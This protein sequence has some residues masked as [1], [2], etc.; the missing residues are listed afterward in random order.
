MSF[1]STSQYEEQVEA[2][3][4]PPTT[5]N[6]AAQIA[7]DP[8]KDYATRASEINAL[9][10]EYPEVTYVLTSADLEEYQFAKY[11]DFFL[12]A[13]SHV[14]QLETFE[15]S[16]PGFS[17]TYRV[18]RNA[19]KGLTAT[20]ETGGAAVFEYYPM[21]VSPQSSRDDL[22][23]ELSLTF[24]DL[25]EILPQELDNVMNYSNGLNIRPTVKYRVY[26]SDD[27]RAPLYGPIT[28][29]VEAFTFNKDGASFDAKAVGI[30]VTRTGEVFSLSRFPALRGFL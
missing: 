23:Y 13:P 8:A 3:G 22:D 1:F 2:S 20:L 15:I 14:A 17:K 21:K 4:A 18:V 19:V 30:N 12:N 16:H 25:G 27:L 28:L 10:E 6:Q 7:V 5:V 11:A 9:F 24:G 29:E 26:R